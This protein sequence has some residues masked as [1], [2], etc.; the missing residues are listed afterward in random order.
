MSK[1]GGQGGNPRGDGQQAW[2]SQQQQ[3]RP[4]KA[5][6]R[7]AVLR[8]NLPT[9]LAQVL[10]AL[11]GET[12]SFRAL[13]RL[14]DSIEVLVK[15][16]TVLVVSTFADAVAEESP[17]LL[18]KVRQALAK[19][20]R[21]P[22]LGVWWSFARDTGSGLT[23]IQYPEPT[24]G[25]FYAVGSDS[26]LAKVLNGG[27]HDLIHFRNG[28]AHGAT[29]EEAQCVADLARMRPRVEALCKVVW[30]L[31]DAE[32]VAVLPGERAL[33]LRGSEPTPC[34]VP[35]GAKAGHTYLLRAGTTPL[36]LH[37]LLLWLKS[38]RG[39][40]AFFYN[41]L[42]HK[43]DAGALHYAWAHRSRSPELAS[44]LLERYPLEQWQDAP[45]DAAD[46]HAI[47]EHIEALTESFKGRRD[48]LRALVGK[49]A[50]RTRGFV[51]LWGAPGIGK[52]AL[53]ARLLQYIDWSEESQR[54]AYPEIEPP[55]VPPDPKAKLAAGES[56]GHGDSVKSDDEDSDEALDEAFNGASDADDGA[57]TDGDTDADDDAS[58]RAEA[59][60]KSLPARLEF[61]VIRT[62][63]RRGAYGETKDIFESLGRQLDRH[64]R[65]SMPGASTAP[66]A[67][68]LLGERVRLAAKQLKE[69]QR[70]LLVIDGLDEAAEH[71][72]FLRGLLREVPDKV[73]VVYGSRPQPVVRSEVYEQ[74]ELLNRSDLELGG[75]GASDM[76]ALLYEHVD[77]YAMQNA[78]AEAIKERSQGNAL[79]MR[80]LCDA[81]DRSEF[82]FNDVTQVP[83]SMSELYDNIV[84][85]VEKTPGAAALLSLLAASHAYLR[86]DLLTDLLGLELPGFRPENTREAVAACLEVLMDDPATPELDWQLFHESLRDYLFKTRPGEVHAWQDKLGEWALDWRR[87]KD[88]KEAAESYALRW[89]ATHL[90]ERAARA[91][92]R[93]GSEDLAAKCDEQLLALVDDPD[94]RARSMRVCGNAESLRRGIRLAQRV[95]VARYRASKTDADRARVARYTEWTWGEE[96][97]LYEAQRQQLRHTHKNAASWRDVHE[98][99]R[100]GS[101]ARERALLAVLSLWGNL[102]ARDTEP[103]FNAAASTEMRVWFVEADDTALHRL[104]TKLRGPV[105]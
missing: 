28:Y 3:P 80:L 22:S 10:D 92:A 57:E 38:P 36:D 95:A 44:A 91:R 99:A 17:A 15:L 90:A 49:F 39:E 32:F 98:L 69:E 97:R 51:M 1:K 60:A 66:E 75:L 84:R 37:P 82:A 21:L 13:H 45:L 104:W 18:P 4:S 40:G 102:G 50:T 53:L 16:H 87:F 83:R 88:T 101:T 61:R 43:A 68:R 67:A 9:P 41:D 103:T 12:Q 2:P 94:W 47:R 93:M 74:L 34:D 26:P 30:W 33:R 25:L 58:D 46:E 59:A 23:S 73:F 24:P 64:F 19:G 76:R 71:G 11:D 31:A 5:P 81:L 96:A 79:Y 42:K 54:A 86:E 8:A 77:K 14:I 29:P 27:Q 35:L 63:V 89:G 7:P 100:V 20:L 105:L 78:W 6:E 48:E 56:A 72:D 62:F 52:S 70:L 65:L 55:R 85:R